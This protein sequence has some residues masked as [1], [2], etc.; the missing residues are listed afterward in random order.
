M[1]EENKEE[2][3][4]GGIFE[5]ISVV[6]QAVLI[7]LVIRV[8]LFQPF[9]IPSE[10]MLPTLKVG[11]YLIVSKYS[12]GY[13]KHS[14]PW[15]LDVF[16]GRIFSSQPER[17][18]IAVFKTPTDNRTDFIKRVIGLPGD[19]IQ[20]I[21]GE[22]YI[23]DEP[24]SREELEPISSFD[25][26]GRETVNAIK[27]YKETLDTGASYITYDVRPLT[28]GDNTPVFEVPED[29]IF[30]IGD[31]RDRSNDSR[32][33]VGFVP[34]ENLLGKAQFIFFSIEDGGAWQFWRWPT[35]ARFDRIFNAL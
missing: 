34:I 1:Q 12:Y 30:M 24:V 17:G 19:K 31:N 32:L 18:D 22:L 8:L 35:D 14:L 2:K 21:S 33:G 3:K 20:M 27:R 16:S 11:D 6:I 7:A 5:I 23:N 13:S 25:A 29:H 26:I 15:S 4:E 9:S 28:Q 10:S